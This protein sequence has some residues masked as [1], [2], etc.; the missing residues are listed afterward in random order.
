MSKKLEKISENLTR[1]ADWYSANKPNLK[2][3][4]ISAADALILREAIKKDEEKRTNDFEL[5]GFTNLG[6][7]S[8]R[9]RNFRIVEQAFQQKSA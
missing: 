8:F 6:D 7:G 3:I 4:T 2:T 1:L 5:A 9:W